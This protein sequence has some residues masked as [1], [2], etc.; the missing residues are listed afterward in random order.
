[1]S[2]LH[3]DAR[4]LL[5]VWKYSDGIGG[6]SLWAVHKSTPACDSCNKDRKGKLRC[7]LKVEIDRSKSWPVSLYR[8]WLTLRSSLCWNPS[9]RSSLSLPLA[10]GLPNCV[11][12][13]LR[14]SAQWGRSASLHLNGISFKDW[15]TSQPHE[16]FC[17][18]LI[19]V[20][21]F[22]LSFCGLSCLACFCS[23]LTT[24]TIFRIWRFL[25]MVYSTRNHWV[26]GLCPSFGISND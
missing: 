20:F 13:R 14:T 4:I 25:T 22:F 10:S 8:S 18:P 9:P 2:E 21:V 19:T 1:M 17:F 11:T 15:V 5:I 24:K 26:S 3:V 7:S 16:C 23:W 6:A 12:V